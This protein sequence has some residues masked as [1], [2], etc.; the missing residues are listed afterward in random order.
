MAVQG[1]GEKRHRTLANLGLDASRTSYPF[2]LIATTNSALLTAASTCYL[3]NYNHHIRYGTHGA[4]ISTKAYHWT[5]RGSSRQVA[6]VE[7]RKEARLSR[8]RAMSIYARVYDT[9][10]YSIILGMGTAYTLIH[11]S[12]RVARLCA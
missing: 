4:A 12:R 11:I 5:P 8:L 9:I 2:S 10:A 3:C 6:R 1:Q 7:D